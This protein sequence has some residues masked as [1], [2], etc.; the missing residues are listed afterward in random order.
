[1][2]HV[3]TVFV[4]ST[5]YDLQ[6]V[7]AD[8]RQFVESLGFEPMMS[9]YNSFPVDPNAAAIENCLTVVDQRADVFVL[10]VGGRY[11]STNEHGKS[12]TN[13]EYLRARAKG[14]PVYAFVKQSILHVLP[15][16]KNNP[17]GDFHSEVDSVK[18]FEFVTSLKDSSGVWVFPFEV[19]QDITATLR[20]QLAYL[21]FESLQ[22]RTR[23]RSAGLSEPLS[24]LIGE[25]LRLVIEH[26][27]GWEYLLFLHQ[28]TQNIGHVRQR[29]F[30]LNYGI[31]LGPV[32]RLSEPSEVFSWISRRMAQAHRFIGAVDQIINVALQEAFGPRG[33]AGDPEKLVYVARTL[34]EIYRTA[35]EWAIECKRVEVDDEEYNEI[36]RLT[37]TL[38][39]DMIREIEN[40]SEKT[41]RETQEALA[42]PL[43]PNDEPRTL[44]FTLEIRAPATEELNKE[45]ERLRAI[46]PK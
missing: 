13:M 35:I 12:V 40:W 37:G 38:S 26:P 44:N 9:E 19:A 28:L 43:G 36:V 1:M 20:K 22:I 33:I 2:A 32:E 4:S 18:L 30:D 46:R 17:E 16:W 10:I 11:G 6:Q 25:P 8:L 14:I 27:P 21:F 41:L 34:S 29:R 5:C 23:S 42:N 7:R 24:H 31:A 15:V 45:L 39:D 3:P